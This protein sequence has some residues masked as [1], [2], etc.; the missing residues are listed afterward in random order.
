VDART[1]ATDATETG[2]AS[3]GATDVSTELT[4]LRADVRGLAESIS[5]L[6]AEAPELA[7]RSF[8]TSIR[9]N[10]LQATLIAAGMGFALSLIIGR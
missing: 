4:A 5:R 6:A 10:P 2:G 8:E 9:R 7:K 3:S 1:Y